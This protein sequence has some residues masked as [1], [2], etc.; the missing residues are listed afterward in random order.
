MANG[1]SK[2]FELSEDGVIEV[3]SGG[4]PLSQPI[5]VQNSSAG[6]YSFHLLQLHLF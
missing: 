2:S 5:N 1:D 6:L 3:G 4:E